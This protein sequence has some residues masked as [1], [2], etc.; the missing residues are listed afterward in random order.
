MFVC[1]VLSGRGLCDE[2]I[3][4]PEE[5]YRLWRVVSCDQE[6]S[7]NEE[8]RARAGPQSQRKWIILERI[9][10]G[11]G[12]TTLQVLLRLWAPTGSSRTTVGTQ[13]VIWWH[14]ILVGNYNYS[15]NAVLK[16]LTHYLNYF[17]VFKFEENHDVSIKMNYKSTNC[18]LLTFS[19]SGSM[20][21]CFIRDGARRGT[22]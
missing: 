5:S 1:C 18:R 13:R 8:A 2:L 9:T 12:G 6:T 21:K 20:R 17:N 10:R 7:G 15:R 11:Y 19:E 3:T 16:M 22:V 4:R 14:A